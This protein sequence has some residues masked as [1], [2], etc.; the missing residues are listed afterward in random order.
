MK[1]WLVNTN[2]NE[3]NGNP[4][5]YKQM[6]RQNKVIPYYVRKENIDK[7]EPQDM[8][9][10]YH[11][12]DR[13][14]AVGFAIDIQND[15]AEIVHNEHYVSVNWFWKADFNSQFEPQNPIDRNKI[16]ITTVSSIVVNITEQVDCRVLLQEV[17]KRQNYL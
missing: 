6:L 13:V 12:N 4:D 9:L 8:V 3:E 16:G 1:I 11:N 17:A 10:L 5:G 15:L 2:A 7:I 14:I